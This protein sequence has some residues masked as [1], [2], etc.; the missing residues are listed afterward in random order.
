MSLCFAVP[1]FLKNNLKNM[2]LIDLYARK[3]EKNIFGYF[4]E[5]NGEMF[6]NSYTKKMVYCNPQ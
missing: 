1:Y 2:K 6:L 3:L 4:K 5:K